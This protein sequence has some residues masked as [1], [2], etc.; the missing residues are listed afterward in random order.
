M[1][2]ILETYKSTL[3]QYKIEIEDVNK[4]FTDYIAKAAKRTQINQQK[5]EALEQKNLEKDKRISD[6]EKKINILVS[7]ACVKKGCT[8]AVYL[9]EVSNE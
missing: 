6:L 2:V 8:E 5:I 4:R 1:K 3:E 7:E 9:K